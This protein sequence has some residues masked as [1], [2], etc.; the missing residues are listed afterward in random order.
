[1]GPE[2]RAELL[3]ALRKFNNDPGKRVGILTGAGRA[4]SAGADISVKPSGPG[5]SVN[6]EDELRNSFHLILK[7]IRFSDK[8]FIAAINGV[9]AGGAG[10]SLAIACDFAFAS[11]N[12][13]FVTAFQNIGLVPDTGLTLMMLD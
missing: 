11:R 4:F 8:L 13:R 9:A 3:D 6:L 1:M 5:G 7:E 10:I 12:A 2:L